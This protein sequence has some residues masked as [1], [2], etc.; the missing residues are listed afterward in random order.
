M[1][2]RGAAFARAFS[3]AKTTNRVFMIN[4]ALRTFLVQILNDGISGNGIVTWMPTIIVG[5]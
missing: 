2:E 5:N 4:C 3:A 1:L